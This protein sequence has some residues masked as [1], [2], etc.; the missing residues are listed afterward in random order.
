VIP[1]LIRKCLEA[2]ERGDDHITCWGTGRASREFLYVTDAAEGIVL[3]AQKLTEPVPVNLGSGREITIKALAELIAE[4]TGFRGEL[5]W[6]PSQ[7]DGQPRRCLDVTRAKDL[8]GW[9]A[10][11]PFR[12]GL[13]RT[14]D[15]YRQERR[16]CAPSS[17]TATTP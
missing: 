13:K 10:R 9:T 15:W 6:D 8:L 14:I 17:S 1:A 2:V 4:L 16:R 11:T 5:R 7:P 3:A 12:E